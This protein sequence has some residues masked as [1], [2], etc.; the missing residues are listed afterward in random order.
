MFGLNDL[1]FESSDSNG[2]LGTISYQIS[3]RGSR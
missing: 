1:V 3:F 2:F